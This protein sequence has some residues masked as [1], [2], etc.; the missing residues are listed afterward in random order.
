MD[1]SSNVQSNVFE[2]LGD[3]FGSALAELTDFKRSKESAAVELTF[4][5]STVRFGDNLCMSN[6]LLNGLN[7][8]GVSLR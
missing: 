5:D 7:A 8:F 6:V 1:S 2:I 3:G 4:F